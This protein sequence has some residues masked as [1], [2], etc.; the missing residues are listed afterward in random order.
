MSV[1]SLRIARDDL[2]ILKKYKGKHWNSI[3]KKPILMMSYYLMETN[4][5]SNEIASFVKD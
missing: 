5:I 4:G 2:I 1:S 3:N